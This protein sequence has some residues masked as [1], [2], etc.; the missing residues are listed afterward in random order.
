[1]KAWLKGVIAVLAAFSAGIAGYALFAPGP[2]RLVAG[3]SAIE[4]WSL[5]GVKAYTTASLAAEW[6][7]LTPW[8][9]PP[10]PPPPPAPPP[11]VPVGVVKAVAGYE[12]IFLVPG[13]GELRVRPG[14][15]LPDGGRLLQVRESTIVWRNAKGERQERALLS[16]PPPPPPPPPP[17]T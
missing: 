12:A 10:P 6:R 15:R 16:G 2:D 5:P 11:L 9:A 17:N 14:A 13:G 1:M 7:R 8:G 4:S 3:R